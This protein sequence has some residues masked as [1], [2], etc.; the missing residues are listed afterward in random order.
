[1]I[2]KLKISSKYYQILT[3]SFHFSKKLP[4]RCSKLYGR[5]WS[6]LLTIKSPYD[7]M[8]AFTIGKG[9][10]KLSF[11][12]FRLFVTLFIFFLPIYWFFDAWIKLINL[13][14]IKMGPA[15]K[16]KNDSTCLLEWLERRN[17]YKILSF[18]SFYSKKWLISRTVHL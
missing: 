14:L 3:M 15:I 12:S 16:L 17:G 4:F 10:K 5:Q 8:P 9:E 18:V 1:M 6:G 2:I 11:C 7:C 13:F